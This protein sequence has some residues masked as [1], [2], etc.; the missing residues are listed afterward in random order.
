MKDVASKHG[1]NR[2]P[3]SDCKSIYKGNNIMTAHAHMDALQNKHA[4]LEAKIAAERMR[5]MPDFTALSRLKKEKLMVK[6]DLTRITVSVP[7]RK[8]A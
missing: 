7:R 4:F 8:K 5:P 2:Q 1:Q 3:H 6:E